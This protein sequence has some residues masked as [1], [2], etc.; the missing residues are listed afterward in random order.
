[1]KLNA[2]DAVIVDAL[3][4]PMGRSRGGCFRQ[5]RA[6][7]LSATVMAALL[8][9]HSALNP[10]EIN[11][12]IWGCVN[13]SGEQGWNIARN[14][15]LLTDIPQSVSAQT[16]NR[17]CGSS[18]TALHT[19]AQ[20]IQSGNGEVFLVGGV[21]HM[22]H[23]P[24]LQG[25]DFNPELARNIA[26]ASGSMGLTA[27]FLARLHGI[28]RAAQD[29]FAL[30]SQQRAAEAAGKGWFLPEITPTVGHDAQGELRCFQQ[31]E[32]IRSDTNAAQLAGLRPVFDPEHGSI[33]AGNASQISDGA[34][35]LLVMS[36]QRANALGIKP[37]AKIRAMAVVGVEPALMGYGPVFASQKALA[38]A[39][40]SMVDIDCVEINEAFAAQTLPVLKDL[41]LLD[42]LDDKVNLWG[43]AI[44]LG[45]PLGASGARICT[46]LLSVMRQKNA[47]FGLAALCIG[48]GQGVATV[49]ER[50]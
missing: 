38:R 31:D 8:A 35:G 5:I 1:M 12:V 26:Q 49:F 43:G 41:Q 29:A 18:M 11:D 40:L 4:T 46:T 44:A 17:L 32:T 2:N 21:E 50:L 10:A 7:T 22:G 24:M 15:A 33:T 34:A 42:A 47:T 39:G 14:A 45:H 9:R 6:E 28:D 48:F 16:V 13:Q 25:F 20:A 23:V 3:R 27:E 30:R 19:A 36:A 37:L